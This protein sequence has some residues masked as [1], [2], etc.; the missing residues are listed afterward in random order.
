MLPWQKY[1]GRMVE[2]IYGDRSGQFS[3]RRIVIRSVQP[4]FIRAYCMERGA[5]RCFAIDRILAVQPVPSAKRTP[6]TS[7]RQRELA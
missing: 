5:V 1:T 6:S 2:I 7:A 4:A 3:K